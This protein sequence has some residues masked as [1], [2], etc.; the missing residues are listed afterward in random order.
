MRSAAKAEQLEAVIVFEQGHVDAAHAKW[1]RLTKVLTARREREDLARVWLNLGICETLRKRP[2]DARRWLTQARAA[3]QKLNNTAELARTRWNMG[4]YLAAFEDGQ[5]ALQSFTSAYRGFLGL[6]MWLDAGCVYLD[7]LE[8]M[9]DV[10]TPDEELTFHACSAADTLAR[11][12]LGEAVARALDQLRKIAR[13][14]DRRRVVRM[15]RA[16]LLDSKASCSEV[17]FVAVGEAG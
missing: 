6:R 3:F 12:G 13:H 9:I 7:M 4:T 2:A 5:R 15:V 11:A 1:V 10:A 14:D 16:A 17:S 8:T